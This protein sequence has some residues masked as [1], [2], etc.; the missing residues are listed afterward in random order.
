VP[1]P[2]IE[3]EIC[4]SFVDSILAE[5]HTPRY[6]HYHSSFVEARKHF[7]EYPEEYE[8]QSLIQIRDKFKIKGSVAHD[9][10]AMPKGHPLRNVSDYAWYNNNYW[11]DLFPKLVL[12]VLRN[13]KFMQDIDFLKKNWETLKFGF[14]FLQTLDIDGDGIPEGNPHEVK[15]TFDNLT[16]F[17]VDSYDATTYMAGCRALSIMADMMDDA[18]AKEKFEA[19]FEK[20]DEAF[21]K[22][23]REHRNKKGITLQYYVTCYDPVTKKMNKDVWTNQLDA[24]WY[25]IAIG[26]ESFIPPDKAKKILKTIY[27]NNKTYMGWAMCRTE[28]GAAVESEQGQDVYTT[29]NY[30]FAQLLDYYGLVKESKEVY[31]AMDKVIFKYANTLIS[32]DNLR[33]ELEQE[34][35]ESA[36]GPHYIVAAY[37]R[38]GAVL[39]QI[40]LQH[41]KELQEKTGSEKIDS[42]P[43]K[44]FITDLMK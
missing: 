9:L 11:V 37:P 1:F 10:S 16:L 7:E 21:E 18:S 8:G 28:N 4:Q 22:L 40:V 2:D 5:D 42:K 30:V 24:L 17:G 36:P 25:L 32:P 33:A 15:N 35:G 14:D 26:E 20:A 43:L 13:V 38:P 6:Y 19:S 23:W 3:R 31:K 34:E 29:S 44:S 12:R 39:T 27:R 41:V